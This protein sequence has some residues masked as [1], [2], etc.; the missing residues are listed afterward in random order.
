MSLLVITGV[1]DG[2]ELEES[3]GIP[4]LLASSTAKAMTHRIWT[5]EIQQGSNANN[6]NLFLF[7]IFFPC[8]AP[9]Q[10][11]MLN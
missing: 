11:C 9:D 1:R 3:E 5:F 6:A 10:A 7:S 4:P 8:A 2:E